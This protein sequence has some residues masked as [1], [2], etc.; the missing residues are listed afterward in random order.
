MLGIDIVLGLYALWV[1]VTACPG[2]APL[3]QILD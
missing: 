1:M 3:R 2:S